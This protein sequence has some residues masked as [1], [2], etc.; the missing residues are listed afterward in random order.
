[1]NIGD[2][3]RLI[4][5]K[6]EG[7]IT[8]ILRNDQVEVELE[9]GFSNPFLRKELALVSRAEEKYFTPTANQSDEALPTTNQ[10]KAKIGIYLSFVPIN[11]N[12]YSLY[13]INNTDYHLPF[14]LTVLKDGST[15]GVGAGYL[16]SKNSINLKEFD[17]QNFENWGTF[18][19]DCFYYRENRLAEIKPF[20]KKVRLRAKSFA[21]SKT[22]SP[23]INQKGHLLQLDLEE[24]T[25]INADEIKNK[26]FGV[27][28]S[29]KS[30]IDI[31]KK[32]SA[33]ID[34]H[35]EELE[36][37][38]LDFNHKKPILEIQ[39][40][41]FERSL[42]SAIAHGMDEITFIHGIGNGVLRDEIHR[43]LGRHKN[44]SYFKDAQ[45]DKFG[46]GATLAK[47]K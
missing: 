26:M 20:S 37:N 30:S 2:K 34:L 15:E 19:F 7:I 1:M 3:V 31:A 6:G 46:Y 21:D 40:A 33:V 32:P 14:C 17:N 22:D 41:E 4:H 8:K 16:T 29:S 12:R 43:K 47:I 35:I 11:G 27:N 18:I 39:L 44:V 9:D 38:S 45:K 5:S 25:P 24:L 36:K 42:E 28:D 23:I 13:L 10:I